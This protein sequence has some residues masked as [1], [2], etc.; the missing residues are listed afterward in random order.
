MKTLILISL[1]SIGLWSCDFSP[2]KP[3]ASTFR[4]QGTIIGKDSG[5]VILS[6]GFGYN[7]RKDTVSI[8][9]GKFEI[10]G[11]LAE[12]ISA[13]LETEGESNR[14]YI[15][16]EPGEMTVEVENNKFDL[17]RVTGSKTQD[18]SVELNKKIKPIDDRLLEVW[19]SRGSVY[20]SINT[21]KDEVSRKILERKC[22]LIDAKYELLSE[23]INEIK[24]DFVRSHP[25]S[26]LSA[27][28]LFTLDKNEAISL[29]SLNGLFNG[30]DSTVQNSFW[31]EEIKKD[32]LKK[33]NNKIGAIAPD[34]TFI[35]IEN[36]TRKLSEF[37]GK[38]VVLDFWASWCTPCRKAFP[39]LKSVFQKYHDQGFE[40]I[41]ISIDR[42]KTMWL[43]AI[44]EDQ[45]EAWNHSIIGT[46]TNEADVAKKYFFSAIPRQYLIDKDGRIAGQWTGYGE[47][48]EQELDK[49][50][51]EIF[52]S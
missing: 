36:R 1:F 21:I 33:E 37:K 27:D 29:D 49:K 25:Q 31:G 30:L 12:P 50:M 10:K 13:Y 42:E 38:C 18:E 52:G 15:Y 19:K 5:T 47:E 51:K 16:I 39:H 45:T 23:Q 22:E 48:N 3:Q 40:V 43:K 14:V 35:D 32:I 8:N 44:K 11:I 17:V 34:F 46:E 4:I 24:F 26:F 28:L 41:A 20:D 6:Y 7:Y 2:K 9:N